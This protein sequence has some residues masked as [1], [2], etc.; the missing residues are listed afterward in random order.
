MDSTTH[1]A[2]NRNKMTLPTCSRLKIS[3]FFR[4]LWWTG[5]EAQKRTRLTEGLRTW[6]STRFL[7][8][9]LAQAS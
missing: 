3:V 1:M 9:S 2:G 7:T 5:L 8:D 4:A 6:T